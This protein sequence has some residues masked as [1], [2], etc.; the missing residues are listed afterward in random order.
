[1][2]PLKNV[3]HTA[4]F[5]AMLCLAAVCVASCTTAD[6]APPAAFESAAATPAPLP[7]GADE[8]AP[9]RVVVQPRVD[10]HIRVLR[11]GALSGAAAGVYAEE[12]GG[13]VLPYSVVLYFKRKQ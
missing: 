6:V 4:L 8:A 10:V 5:A 2:K 11:G 12:R 7:G 9:D 3:I 1:M 13:T